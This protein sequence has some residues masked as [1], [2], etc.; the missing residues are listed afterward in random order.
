MCRNFLGRFA[1]AFTLIELLVVIA[2]IAILAALLLPA[3]AAAREKARRTACMNNLKQMGIALESYSSDFNDFLPSWIGSG[4]MDWGLGAGS[5]AQ[6]ASQHGA[7]TPC[8]SWSSTRPSETDYDRPWRDAVAFYHGTATNYDVLPISAGNYTDTEWLDFT[9]CFR[10]I[11]MG[12]LANHNGGADYIQKEGGGEGTTWDPVTSDWDG[13]GA[14][15]DVINFAPHGLGHLLVGGYMPDAKVYY[16]PSSDGMLPDCDEFGGGWNLAHWKEAG[17]Y[18]KETMLYGEGWPIQ[19][20]D[21]SSAAPNGFIFS[22]YA[23][24]C[25]PMWTGDAWCYAHEE[26]K[27]PKSQLAF[28]NP[29][30]HGVQGS[31]WFRTRKLL[32]GR[33][34]VAD[35]FTKIVFSPSSTYWGYGKDGLGVKLDDAQTT[36]IQG[37]TRPGVSIKSHRDAYN[38]LYGDNHAALYQDPLEKIVWHPS[39][40][41]RHA[42]PPAVATYNP[43]TGTGN[44]GH[45][46]NQLWTWDWDPLDE[47]DH[48]PPLVNPSTLAQPNPE[49][50]KWQYSSAKIWHDFD[51]AAGFD[52]F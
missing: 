23:Y 46:G 30:V 33:A 17:G 19:Y 12:S 14:G 18:D 25:T 6:C 48:G 28:T 34:V 52:V 31:P 4:T 16:C 38:V 7:A 21:L 11:A 41:R 32:S 47:S 43:I 44:C 24:R 35:G 39:Y 13:A 3:L 2:I 36:P 40:H 1:K 49:G 15:S 27:N 51:V 20:E 8:A 22:H 37:L 50:M 9:S 45:L 5:Y 26:N 42:Y 29:G 10:V